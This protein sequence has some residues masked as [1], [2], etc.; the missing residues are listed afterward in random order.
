MIEG[1]GQK[2]ERV[3]VVGDLHLGYEE[4]L[5]EAGILIG[6][7]MLDELVEDFEEIFRVVK[8]VDKIILLGDVKHIFSGILKQE[9]NDVLELID[10]LFKHCQE[11]RVTRGN[12]DNYLKNIVE[13]RK[14]KVEDYVVLGEYCFLHG[15]KDFPEIYDKKIKY[16]VVGHTHPAIKLGDG[17]KVEK[18]K[19]FVSGKYK[20]KNIII[21]PSFFEYSEGVDVREGDLNLAWP[22]NIDKFEVGVVGEDLKVLNFGILKKIK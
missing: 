12:H 4:A 11:I 7:K 21:V 20:G 10:F 13:K 16:W 8:R 6:R 18:Y 15:D 5:N 22:I 14:V 17:V 1:V 3:L 9:W 2:K 19:C